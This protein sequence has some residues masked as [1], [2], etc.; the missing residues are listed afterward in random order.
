MNRRVFI[1]NAAAVAV[2]GPLLGH[3]IARALSPE[4]ADW[5]AGLAQ[6]GCNCA[7]SQGAPQP[8]DHRT[9]R[10]LVYQGT[11]LLTYGAFRELAE[12][13]R[14]DTGRP[15][16]VYGGGC[17]DGIGAVQHRTA[18]LGGL[19]CPVEET[20][21]R[22]F[23]HLLVARDLKVVVTHPKVGIDG[24][25]MD[26]LK[27]I[28][29]GRIRRWSEV[30]GPDRPIAVLYRDHCPDYREPVRDVLFDNAQQWSPRGMSIDTDEHLTDTLARF[31]SSIAVV[32]WVFAADRVE[33]GELRSLKIDGVDP[34]A[35]AVQAGDYPLYGPL[36]V[37]S[38]RWQEAVMRP[39]FDYLYSPAGQS[40][41]ARRLIPVSAQEAGYRLP[42]PI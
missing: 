32:S 16:V 18:H 7:G 34:S 41:V 9:D 6:G 26:D 14:D 4:T 36:A 15:F 10:E 30:G 3:G 20:R 13:Y 12:H 25:S 23:F 33:R 5:Q 22:D 1:R 29:G 11:H 27:A 8:V 24:L 28:M 37:V 38:D 21:A 19:C 42:Q 2:L 17:D 39:F 31:E 35:A 40:V